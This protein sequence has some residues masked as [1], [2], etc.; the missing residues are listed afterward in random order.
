MVF[1]LQLNAFECQADVTAKNPSKSLQYIECLQ[2]WILRNGRPR[3]LARG[4]KWQRSWLLQ[5]PK[6]LKFI[7][8]DGRK[9]WRDLVRDKIKSYTDSQLKILRDRYSVPTTQSMFLVP[10]LQCSLRENPKFL[11]NLR[12]KNNTL[13]DFFY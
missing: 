8:T 11:Q 9:I 2:T 5:L 10:H 12:Y 7:E 3:G 4:S 6:K 13:K 1:K